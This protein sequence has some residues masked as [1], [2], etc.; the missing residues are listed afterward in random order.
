M[1]LFL[2]FAVSLAFSIPHVVAQQTPLSWRKPNITSSF[3]DRVSIAGA[4]IEKAVAFIDSTTAQFPGESYGVAGTFYSQLAE[5]DAATNQTKYGDTLQQ[6][7]L[8]AE[9]QQGDELNVG[10]LATKDFTL[11][12]TCQGITM[13]GG[14]FYNQDL[15]STDIV[16][17]ATGNFL[18]LSALL[19]EAT[20]EDMYLEAARDSANF[21]HAHLYSVQNV[22]YDGIPAGAN[23]SC[24]PAN[25]RES[26]NSGLVIEGLA[27]L[28][29]ITQNASIHDLVGD[30]LT[31]AI[32]NTAWQGG[33]GIVATGG[34]KMGDMFIVRGLS[35]AYLR[36]VTTPALKSYIEDYL[37]V[38]FNAVIDLSTINGSDIY[39]GSWIGSH[40]LNKPSKP[41]IKFFF[42][43]WTYSLL[44][45]FSQSSSSSSSF[46]RRLRLTNFAIQIY[47]NSLFHCTGC[48]RHSWR[49]CAFGR[50]G[51]LRR[52][53]AQV[54]EPAKKR[55]SV[56]GL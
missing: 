16:G 35:T 50:S 18:V 32:P 24:A 30:I 6:Y 42:D 39:G 7:F 46:P 45:L 40:Q 43:S 17:L 11:Q 20:S 19:A 33:D 36:N 4:A 2:G 55:E 54:A 14:T 56:H 34:N 41:N 48:W 9:Q 5:F 44:N 26:Y 15:T 12:K 22:V 28:Y 13:V 1:F 8:L 21:I 27:I 37:S 25:L 47:E 52:S 38:Q 3:P 10:T 31:A 53:L 29:S 49:P 51:Q 23:D